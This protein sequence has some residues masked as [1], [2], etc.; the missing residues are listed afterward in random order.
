[1]A[2]ITTKKTSARNRKPARRATRAP[3]RAAPQR[4]VVLV[5]TRKGQGGE[6]GE[7]R[8]PQPMRAQ[9]RLEMPR[10]RPRAAARGQAMARGAER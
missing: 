5:A 4:M 9:L 6:D 3:R 8:G 10:D 1:M 7:L 2:R